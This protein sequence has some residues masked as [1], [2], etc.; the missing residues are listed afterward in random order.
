M[1]IVK[2]LKRWRDSKIAS[3][4][5]KRNELK[6]PKFKSDSP[7]A[8]WKSAHAANFLVSRSR[9]LVESLSTNGSRLMSAGFGLQH[10]CPILSPPQTGR[11]DWGQASSEIGGEPGDRPRDSARTDCAEFG[12]RPVHMGAFVEEIGT[13]QVATKS[14]TGKFAW[15]DE[16][17]KTRK[18]TG[19]F[20]ESR[21][22]W[23][24]LV[25]KPN[26][27][28]AGSQK[29]AERGCRNGDRPVSIRCFCMGAK[30]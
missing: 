24:R 6:S 21:V 9:R 28:E 2:N 22:N 27:G 26:F 30:T 19:H 29:G 7:K 10:A 17:V 16:K 15:E 23:Q 14:K 1:R 20:Q 13:V 8:G 18:G 3:S 4:D 25:G 5:V 12:D 11:R